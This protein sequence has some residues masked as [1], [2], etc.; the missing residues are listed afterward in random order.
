MELLITGI[1]TIILIAMLMMYG[2]AKQLNAPS[3][4]NKAMTSFL[5][6]T[7]IFTGMAILVLD[8]EPPEFLIFDVKEIVKETNKNDEEKQP[9]SKE[10]QNYFSKD[11]PFALIVNGAI[12]DFYPSY[13]AAVDAAKQS[14]QR[15][16][17]TFRN[18]NNIVWEKRSSIP[19]EVIQAPLILQMPELPRGC[20]VTSL[21][22][23]LNYAGFDTNKMELAEQI[24][25][26]E[27]SYRIENGQIFFGNPYDGFVGDMYTFDNPGYG[28]Y[29]RP[30]I[31]LAEEYMPD[32]IVNMTGA[33]FEDILYP[34]HQGRPVWV[35]IHTQFRKLPKSSFQRWQ[36]PS[37]EV[38]I[39][40]HQHS[41]LITGYDED[42]I[43]FNDPLSTEVNR[44]VPIKSFREAWIQMGRQAITYVK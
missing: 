34:L 42:T 17:V 2:I 6:I 31:E 28:V 19:E 29:Y 8:I 26:D 14:D 32:K 1:V 30:V 3:L 9:R 25:K 10:E 33:D 43:F 20:E 36:T 18:I 23:M 16:F 27:T 4:F 13:K 21:A 7:G 11:F 38:T 12:T 5:L 44:R 37:G 39:T 41:V 40:Y 35:I 15:T 22:M 24:R